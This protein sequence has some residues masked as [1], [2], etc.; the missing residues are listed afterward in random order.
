[1]RQGAPPRMRCLRGV[2]H[3]SDWIT[4][5][6][7]I[8]SLWLLSFM[9][10]GYTVAMCLGMDK[11]INTFRRF[12]EKCNNIQNMRNFLIFL[13]TFEKTTHKCVQSI[14]F[15]ACI[16]FRSIQLQ[17]SI[18]FFFVCK[19]MFSIGQKLLIENNI[20]CVVCGVIRLIDLTVRS[21]CINF[22][23]LSGTVSGAGPV[24]TLIINHVAFDAMTPSN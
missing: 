4:W 13:F 14:K 23:S 6:D 20:K 1:M 22:L 3:Y 15:S 5:V 16:F 21:G 9:T 11:M 7:R 18:S 8:I 12:Y 19:C 10:V 24:E 2:S 17:F